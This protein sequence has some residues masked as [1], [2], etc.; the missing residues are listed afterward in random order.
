MALGNSNEGNDVLDGGNGND[1]L[2]GLG[3][4]DTLI[5]GNGDDLLNGGLGNDTLT[6]GNGADRFVLAANEG[7]DTIT[8]F[9]KGT[10]LIA[11]AGGLSFGS[12]S[13]S[14]NNILNG[15][16]VLATL[17]GVDTTTLTQSNFVTV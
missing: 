7:S 15:S 4:N 5:G 8:D 11:L 1:S 12:L 14:G 3:G 16:E 6:G 9:K 10:D 17:T 13:F 2:I